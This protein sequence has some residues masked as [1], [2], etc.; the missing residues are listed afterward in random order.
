VRP[1]VFLVLFIITASTA[2][3]GTTESP[4]VSHAGA[5][6]DDDRWWKC[7]GDLSSISQGCDT[8]PFTA[9]GLTREE[10]TYVRTTLD[11]IPWYPEKAGK[12]DVAKILGKVKVRDVPFGLQI[13]NDLGPGTE[14]ER[15]VRVYYWK[16]YVWQV[17]WFRPYR[18]FLIKSHGEPN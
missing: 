5:F 3:A 7:P 11:R 1:P 4:T 18:F 6:Q 10:E 16:G 15:E 12:E 14:A 17:R 8:G 13:Y 9:L 2:L